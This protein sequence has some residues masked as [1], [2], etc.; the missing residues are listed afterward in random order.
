MTAK[1]I[2]VTLRNNVNYANSKDARASD[3]LAI[4]KRW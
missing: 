4:T 1:T 2:F 3:N